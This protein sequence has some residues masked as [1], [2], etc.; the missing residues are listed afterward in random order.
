M[1][2]SALNVTLYSTSKL[3]PVI[4]RPVR[5]SSFPGTS[6]WSCPN[7]TF[8]LVQLPTPCSG[9]G[10]SPVQNGDFVWHLVVRTLPG[11]FLGMGPAGPVCKS[12][13]HNQKPAASAS[14]SCHLLIKPPP[15]PRFSP[16]RPRRY[17]PF[18]PPHT[19][20]KKVGLSNRSSFAF[21]I[22]Q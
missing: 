2:H 10:L 1:P 22:C 9:S 11:L 15:P 14:H 20:L 12:M 21:V 7:S 5:G 16:C 4:R 17:L 8:P 6:C 3:Q 13:T 19:S 18:S